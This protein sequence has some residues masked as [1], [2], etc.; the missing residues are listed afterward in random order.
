[1]LSAAD[2][3]VSLLSALTCIMLVP[4]LE[5]PQEGFRCTH[6]ALAVACKA[7]LPLA[8]AVLLV[9]KLLLLELLGL[10]CATLRVWERC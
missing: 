7:L 1:M 3:L 5:T 4:A 8:L 6:N 2:V 10:V 9:L